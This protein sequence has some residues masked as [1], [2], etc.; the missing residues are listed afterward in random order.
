MATQWVQK[1]RQRAQEDEASSPQDE[2][3]PALEA[4]QA[5]ASQG[6][7]HSPLQVPCIVARVVN[8]AYVH[9]N[10][11]FASPAVSSSGLT[12]QVAAYYSISDDDE[13]DDND[14]NDDI[15]DEGNAASTYINRLHMQFNENRPRTRSYNSHNGYDEREFNVVGGQ[16]L[17]AVPAQDE[18]SRSLSP[19][20]R[21][22]SSGNRPSAL[23]LDPHDGWNNMQHHTRRFI[24]KHKEKRRERH[25]QDSRKGTPQKT[26]K[27]N[28]SFNN[29]TAHSSNTDDFT[30]NN[31]AGRKCKSKE[32]NDVL[33]AKCEM[34][35]VSDMSDQD[36]DEPER[37]RERIIVAPLVQHMSRHIPRAV[38]VV[39][40]SI[41]SSYGQVAAIMEDHIAWS[42]ERIAWSANGS[43]SASATEAV[44]NLTGTD[45]EVKKMNITYPPLYKELSELSLERHSSNFI[46][47]GDGVSSVTL[48]QSYSDFNKEW[49]KVFEQQT[50]A[51][52]VNMNVKGMSNARIYE[53]DD[54]TTP[55]VSAASSLPSAPSRL[56][57]PTALRAV[58]PVPPAP[59]DEEA[60]LDGAVAKTNTVASRIKMI[61]RR[62]DIEMRLAAGQHGPSTPRRQGRRFISSTVTPP[63]QSSFDKFQ[64]PKR[65]ETLKVIFVSSPHSEKA[66][67]SI[68]RGLSKQKK[69]KLSNTVDMNVYTWEPEGLC[70][71]DLVLGF[72]ERKP[73]FH[74]WDLKGGSLESGAHHVSIGE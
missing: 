26:K 23:C 8:T 36:Q 11:R 72:S 57:R 69:R 38:Q 65:N 29:L 40:R 63:P 37:R 47:D 49:R 2:S 58:A 52:D 3:I 5:Q 19:S 27:R 66:K 73:R 74:L 46:D 67:T 9:V 64:P 30:L 54:D 4:A 25:N 55:S 14:N 43:S 33:A 68:V 50:G 12:P 22:P 6:G 41:S 17:V 32:P 51:D 34:E 61:E 7:N 35:F 60:V 16:G 42:E 24:N 53:G 45:T 39:K 62:E 20:N 59:V 70:T 71:D 15:A 31:R 13:D 10:N 48:D 28:S 21:R 18:R 1:F 44:G 56:I